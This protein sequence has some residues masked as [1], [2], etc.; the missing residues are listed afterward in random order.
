MLVVGPRRYFTG[1]TALYQLM[2][3][4]RCLYRTYKALGTSMHCRQLIICDNNGCALSSLRNAPR[5]SS[6]KL[7]SVFFSS[8]HVFTSH[9]FCHRSLSKTPEWRETTHRQFKEGEHGQ[10][11]SDVEQHISWTTERT[12][13]MLRNTEQ[14]DRRGKGPRS[15]QHSLPSSKSTFSQP[16]QREMYT[17]GSENWQYLSPE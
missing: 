16:L 8:A 11:A 15:S 9:A 4:L 10:E 14:D 17:W 1:I 2:M 13:G 12:S 6:N 7:V 5:A 3:S